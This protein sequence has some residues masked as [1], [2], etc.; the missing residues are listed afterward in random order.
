MVSDLQKIE[1]LNLSIEENSDLSFLH[2]C[3]NLKDLQIT[4]LDDKAI[5]YLSNLPTLPN[6]EAISLYNIFL[7]VELNENN[8]NF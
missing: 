4:C 8:I 6:L 7:D 5:N 3:T 2:H 1:Y